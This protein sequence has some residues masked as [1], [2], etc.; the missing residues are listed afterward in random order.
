MKI[1]KIRIAVECGGM[2]CVRALYRQAIRL[3]KVRFCASG[4]VKFTIKACD[5]AKTF[6][7]LKNLCYNY[8][9][10]WDATVFSLLKSAWLRSGLFAGIAVC[11]AFIAVFSR[12]VT[13]VKVECVGEIDTKEVVSAVSDCMK[14]PVFR[15][16]VS[17]S[18][19]E[20]KVLELNGVAAC[21]VH[22]C[23]NALVIRAVS[24]SPPGDRTEKTEIVSDCDAIITRLNVRKG[25]ALKKIGDA[26][27]KGEPIISGDIYSSDG[28][29]VVGKVIPDGEAWG[30]TV[31]TLGAVY[32]EKT[33]E[34]KHTGRVEKRALLTLCG[35]AYNPKCGFNRYDEQRECAA[36]GIFLPLSY[37][38]VTFREVIFTETA[39]DCEREAEKMYDKLRQSVFGSEIERK[40]VITELG[41]GVKKVTVHI[42]T[43]RKIA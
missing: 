22:V 26:V 41:G 4:S 13:F 34:K 28:Q 24:S 2:R 12:L 11:I 23:G 32:P 20:K 8:S 14:F 1:N 9:V 35:R 10:V 25:T 6:A 17:V 3:E 30:R 18:D 37:N 21:S 39:T 38:V 43:E 40:T 16:S 27:K 42:V 19:V 5:K 29:T 31:Y 36:T 15:Q 33:V 7:I